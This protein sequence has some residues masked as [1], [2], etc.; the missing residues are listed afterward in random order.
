MADYVDDG[1]GGLRRA[2]VVTALLEVGGWI[3]MVA[4]LLWG[5]YRIVSAAQAAGPTA[6]LDW[7]TPLVLMVFGIAGGAMMLGLAE[8][9][10][11]LDLVHGAAEATAEASTRSGPVT[12]ASGFQDAGNPQLEELTLLLREV[13]DISL[14]SEEQRRL[15]LEAQGRA[16]LQIAQREVPVLLREHNW[17]EA[18]NRVQGARERF[19]SFPEWDELEKQIESMRLQVEMHDVE[20]AERQIHDLSALGAWDRVAEVVKE[21]LERHPDS[22]RAN[23]LAHNV[24]QQRSKVEAEQRARLMS[25]AQD[26]SN[27]RDWNTALQLANTIVQRYPKSPEA[28]ALRLQLPTLRENAEIKTRQTLENEFRQLIK[29]QR[30]NEALRIAQEVLDQYPNS[31]QAT[32]LRE[33]MPKLE[34]RAV[35]A[36][37]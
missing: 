7:V 10:R 3:V 9:I 36:R 11:R 17:I 8:M 30:F 1:G 5:V 24:R 4:A 32:F 29:D 6:G 26:A 27:R 14:L 35:D 28:Q 31:K 33:Q 16:A 18:R 20:A 2:S 23:E 19:P 13:R 12:P 37:R 15:R 21:L 34:A 25:Q 22:E